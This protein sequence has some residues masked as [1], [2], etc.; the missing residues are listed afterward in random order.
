MLAAKRIILLH[1]NNILGDMLRRAIKKE[2]G[3]EIVKEYCSMQALLADLDAGQVPVAE[4]LLM[5]DTGSTSQQ[6][7]EQ[8]KRVNERIKV[9]QVA[10]DGSHVTVYKG[11]QELHQELQLQ[12]LLKLLR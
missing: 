6:I 9:I 11:A 2:F 8:V 10:S 4:D 1:N 12:D 7:I 3:L 5:L